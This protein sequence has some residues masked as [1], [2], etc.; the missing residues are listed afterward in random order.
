MGLSYQWNKQPVIS[1]A[2]IVNNIIRAD[3]IQ[4]SQSEILLTRHYYLSTQDGDC[5]SF[6]KDNESIFLDNATCVGFFVAVGVSNANTTSQL[7]DLVGGGIIAGFGPVKG[8]KQLRQ[9]NIGLGWGRRFG[10][11]QLGDGFSNNAPP[12]IGETQVRYKNIDIPVV[13][14]MYTYTLSNN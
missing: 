5:K 8:S 12:P 14:L 11:K 9:H 10:V 7:F 4:Q 13:F 6:K 2:T 3:S 1:N